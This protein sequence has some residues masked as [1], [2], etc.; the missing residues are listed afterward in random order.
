MGEED[1]EGMD[2]AAAAPA[3]S[4]LSSRPPVSPLLASFIN[5]LFREPTEWEEKGKGNFQ[6]TNLS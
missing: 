2:R 6:G 5:A 4:P 1:G 3:M